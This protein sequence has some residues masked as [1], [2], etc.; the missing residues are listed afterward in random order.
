MK[1]KNRVFLVSLIGSLALLGASCTWVEP[2][3][4]TEGIAL[5]KYT[6]AQKCQKL[7]A[8]TSQV[9][10]SVGFVQRGNK[11]VTTELVTLAKNSAIN[12]G[13]DTITALGPEQDGAQKFGIYKCRP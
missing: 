11:K 3:E 1:T 12:M 8:T 6:A 2:M 5:V 7:G 10:D 4:G 9:K 13:G